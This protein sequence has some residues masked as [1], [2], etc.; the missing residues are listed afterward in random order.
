M[1]AETVADGIFNSHQ[2]E[3][4]YSFECS[5]CAG[6]LSGKYMT[7]KYVRRKSDS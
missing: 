1:G 7:E 3:M 5:Y 4:L 2:A 6:S